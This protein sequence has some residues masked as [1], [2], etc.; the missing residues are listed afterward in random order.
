M[1]KDSFFWNVIYTMPNQEKKI[2]E[3]LSKININSYSPF[4]KTTRQWHDRK[5]VIEIPLFPAYVFV[6]VTRVEDYH[7][8]F[9][10][11]G[12]IN[13]VKYNSR[14]A[15][16]DQSVIDNIKILV[17]GDKHVEVVTGKFEAGELAFINEG[18]LC[19]FTCEMVKYNGKEKA[20]VRVSLLNRNIL[21]DLPINTMTK[22]EVN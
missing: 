19:G 13:W 5:K 21:V 2:I 1:E 20:L 17:N 14:A 7:K 22:K 10:I 9:S 16:V 4:I 15:V 12:V 18:P 8:V 6:K 3:S 11:N